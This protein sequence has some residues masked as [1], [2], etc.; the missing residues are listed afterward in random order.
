MF[1]SLL[2]VVVALLLCAHPRGAAHIPLPLSG[3]LDGTAYKIRVP[4]PG[5]AHSWFTSMVPRPE[6][7][8][9]LLK[10]IRRP[11]RHS[12]TGFSRSAMPWRAPTTR[13]R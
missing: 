3:T 13:T 10:R 7:G 2:A 4:A 1:R 8:K 5:T 12:K 11:R 9:S 6:Q